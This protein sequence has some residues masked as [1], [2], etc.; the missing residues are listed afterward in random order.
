MALRAANRG[1]VIER[2][3]VVTEGAAGRLLADPEIVAA[4]LGA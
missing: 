3:R 4:Y 2:G 1:Y